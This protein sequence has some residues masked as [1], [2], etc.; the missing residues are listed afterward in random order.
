TTLSVLFV[1]IPPLA[2]DSSSTPLRM[3]AR[4]N[5]LGSQSVFDA[6]ENLQWVPF[7]MS[8]P[9]DAVL[10]WNTYTSCFEYVCKVDCIPGYYTPR[11]GARCFFAYGGREHYSESFQILDN[12][13]KFEL[14]E[15]VP[16]SYGTYPSSAVRAC[17]HTDV[18]VGKNKYG[19][20]KV[21]SKNT[22]FFL[23]WKGKEYYYKKYDVLSIKRKSYSQK[24][25]NVIYDISQANLQEQPPQI[26]KKS[27]VDN[28]E[29]QTVKKTV[30]LEATTKNE[31]RWDIQR[32]SMIG[33]SLIFTAGIPSVIAGTITISTE[34]TFTITLGQT[35][36]TSNGHS[37]SIEVNVPPNYSCR[38]NMIG[39]QM[40]TDIPYT[41]S[42]SR[43]YDDGNTASTTIVGTYKGL[44]VGEVTAVVERCVKI[45][46]A[47]PC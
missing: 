4:L 25:S 3:S 24:I 11:K 26:L 27:S 30:I 5:L 47:Q 31:R 37:L 35:S 10:I 46:N 16:G 6:S 29:C 40:T 13:D 19:L 17:A 41:A 14:L 23:P 44:D 32:S 21:D 2:L 1:F 43:T 33:A 38:V 20:G 7:H 42:L 12:K 45:P 9:K 34:K 15:W 28:H 22:A 8:A 39:K 36:S 18:F